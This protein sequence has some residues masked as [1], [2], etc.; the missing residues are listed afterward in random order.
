M[1]SPSPPSSGRKRHSVAPFRQGNTQLSRLESLKNN[2]VLPSPTPR[3]G[4]RSTASANSSRRRSS[5]RNSTISTTLDLQQ[6]CGPESLSASASPT[7]EP[8][9]HGR[10]I[11]RVST[12]VEVARALM[13][14]SKT[15]YHGQSASSLPLLAH[16]DANF[17]STGSTHE[18]G[19]NNPS[20]KQ[21][22]TARGA[23]RQPLP[24]H[25]EG[26]QPS[27]RRP[28]TARGSQSM[29]RQNSSVCADTLYDIRHGPS[30][31]TSCS[32]RKHCLLCPSARFHSIQLCVINTSPRI[33]PC[34]TNG[35]F[36]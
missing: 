15:Q 25:P 26:R 1:S 11:R 19:M 20:P 12:S 31:F 4:R 34:I 9:I 16:T 35:F 29:S 32:L 24:A 33:S 30:P 18:Q 6:G 8:A 28:S 13:A 36:R 10:Q 17:A 27:H 3:R 21:P 7:R 14:S 5:A 2:D 23:M 22:M